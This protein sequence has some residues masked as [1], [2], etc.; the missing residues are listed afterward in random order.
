VLV[1]YVGSIFVVVCILPWNHPGIDQPYVTALEALHIPGAAQIMNG[2][3]LTA[4]LS[5]LNSGLFASSR[6]ILALARRGDAPR[7]LAKL[8]SRG[9]PVRAL[10][11]GTLFGYIAV[12]MSYVSPDRVFA[13]LVNSY[14]TVAIFVYLLIAVAELTLRRRLER[15]SPDRLRVRMWGYPYLTILAILAMVAIVSAMA[16]IPSLR[17]SLLFGVVSAAAMVVGY[18]LRNVARSGSLSVSRST[19]DPR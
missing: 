5:A 3:I 14:G 19:A 13:F 9:V 17:Y 8:N 4:E 18:A 16:F 11:T 1:F 15:E 6:M 10:V 12:V 2:V 7:A